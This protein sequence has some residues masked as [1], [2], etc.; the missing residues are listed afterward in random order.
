MKNVEYTDRDIIAATLMYA[1]VLGNRQLLNLMDER[2]SI[3]LSQHLTES[4]GQTV[5]LLTK[6][7]ADVDV[8]A[9]YN[10]EGNK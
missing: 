8:N 10:K 3:G 6:Q 1:H 4:F 2:A 7:I 9:V 5:H